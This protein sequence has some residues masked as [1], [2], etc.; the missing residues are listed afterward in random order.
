MVIRPGW[1]PGSEFPI[2]PDNIRNI[3]ETTLKFAALPNK[4]PMADISCQSLRSGG[5]TALF[6][7]GADMGAIQKWGRWSSRCFVRYIWFS[8]NGMRK[9]GERTLQCRPLA[10]QIKT[11]VAPR[12]RTRLSDTDDNHFRIGAFGLF[13]DSDDNDEYRDGSRSLFSD[14]EDPTAAIKPKHV[15]GRYSST[16]CRVRRT[17]SISENSTPQSSGA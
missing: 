5:A 15:P 9:L 1:D 4:I 2:S 6:H 16:T 11:A 7:V 10:P 13:S 8:A 3:V 14:P 12:K 17:T